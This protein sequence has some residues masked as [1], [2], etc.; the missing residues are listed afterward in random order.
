MLESGTPKA[1]MVIEDDKFLSSL[2]KTR[3]EGDGYKVLQSFNGEEAI[4][5]I[6][7]GKSK[8]DL[9]ILDLIMPKLSGF[10]VLEAFSTNPELNKIPVIVL[11]NLAQD[12]DIE[13]AS[14][15]G[16]TEFFVKIRISVDDLAKKVKSM[17]G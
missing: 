4:E 5:A 13:K 7:D 15:L 16:A 9:I 8:P 11:S 2:I 3:L 12:S 17:I 6:K 10:E 14:R 1:V